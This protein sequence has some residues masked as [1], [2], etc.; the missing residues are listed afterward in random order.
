MDNLPPAPAK[1]ALV[2]G[3][4]VLAKEHTTVINPGFRGRVKVVMLN[5]SDEDYDLKKGTKI[6]K[7]MFVNTL[8]NLNVG[9]FEGP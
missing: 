8:Q 6:A 2:N 9:A 7:L 1:C 3:K 5:L 4:F